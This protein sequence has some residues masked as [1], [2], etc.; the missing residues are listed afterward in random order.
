MAAV[1][2]GAHGAPMI[3]ENDEVTRAWNGVL[4]D[5]FTRFKHLLT[6][7]LSR[8]GDALLRRSPPKAGW[9]VV[10]L[11]CGFGDMTR[12]LANAVAQRP[13]WTAVMF[14]PISLGAIGANEIGGRFSFPGSYTVRPETLRAVLM[15]LASSLGEQDFRWVFIIDMHGALLHKRV[16]DQAAAYFGD[17]YRGAMVNLFGLAELFDAMIVGDKEATAHLTEAQR[18]EEGFSVHAGIGETSQV[19]YLRPDLVA[20]VTQAPSVTVPDITNLVEVAHRRGLAWLLWRA[21]VCDRGGRSA[22][23]AHRCREG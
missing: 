1:H 3:D 17:E 14:P 10:D 9:R 15:D 4:F 2:I 19:L 12:Q 5:K 22:V 21:K 18:A 16:L 8:H 7:G 6:A 13:G 20:D 11:G 23:V